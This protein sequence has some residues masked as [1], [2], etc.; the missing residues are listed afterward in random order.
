VGGHGLS[1]TGTHGAVG[2][3]QSVEKCQ[4]INTSYLASPEGPVFLGQLDVDKKSESINGKA[5]SKKRRK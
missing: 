2:R 3:N 1:Q 5:V 4:P